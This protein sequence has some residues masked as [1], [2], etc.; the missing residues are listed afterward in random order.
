MTTC[1]SLHALHNVPSAVCH[2][3]CQ[4]LSLTHKNYANLTTYC[5]PVLQCNVAIEGKS[6]HVYMQ[7][8]GTYMKPWDSVCFVLVLLV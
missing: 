5:N 8:T 4:T 2:F 7:T 6:F 3:E 1:I